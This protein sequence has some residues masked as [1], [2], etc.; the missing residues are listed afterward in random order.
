MDVGEYVCF[1]VFLYPEG[2]LKQI[3]KKHDDVI[4]PN[5]KLTCILL[6][7][8]FSRTV[9]TDAGILTSV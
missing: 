2:Q 1:I 3:P 6:L 4:H 7:N 9:L 8:R 5:L